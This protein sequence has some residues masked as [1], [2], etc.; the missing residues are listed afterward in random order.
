MVTLAVGISGSGSCITSPR[1]ETGGDHPILGHDSAVDQTPLPRGQFPVIDRYR[2]FNHAGVSPLPLVAQQ[3]MAEITDDFVHAG[4][5]DFDR[6]EN[7]QEGT[8]ESVARLMG[9]QPTDLAFVKNTTEGLGFVAN[10]LRWKPGDRVIVPDL[11]FPSTIYPWLSLRDHGVEVDIVEPV[12]DTRSLPLELFEDA[13]EANKDKGGTRIVAASWVQYARGFRLEPPDLARLCHEYGALLCLDVIQGLGVLPAELDAWGVDFAMADSHKWMVGPVG[14]GTLFVAERC[15]EL[16]RPLEPGW[17]SVRH[18]DDYDNLELI[19]DDTA[20][21]FEGGTYNNIT[22]Q[23]MGAAAELLLASGIDKIWEHV[24]GLV[25]HLSDGL[26]DAGAV[27]WSD[28][29]AGRSGIVTFSIPGLDTDTVE[30]ALA[31]NAIAVAPRGGG[32]RVSPH[33]YNTTDELDVLVT[34][35]R[36]LVAGA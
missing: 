19:Y 30:N 22:I 18:R 24:D 6:W 17:A 23:G 11:E 2:Y 26:E 10:G 5:I 31:D 14:I 7:A 20:R 36:S 13:L 3:A 32:I 12:G 27:V 15:R 1:R 33:G 29:G 28:R 34:I 21:R 4:A 35:V 16:L 25:T 8:R 9:V